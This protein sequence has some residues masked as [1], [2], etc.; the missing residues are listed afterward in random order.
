MLRVN[1]PGCLF[2][3]LLRLLLQEG[4]EIEAPVGVPLLRCL[5]I[6]NISTMGDCQESASLACQHQVEFVKKKPVVVCDLPI[7]CAPYRRQLS[8]VLGPGCPRSS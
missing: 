7:A 8:P 3:H 4:V 5:L 1:V 2:L 6:L